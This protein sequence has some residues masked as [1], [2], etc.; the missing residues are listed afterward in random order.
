MEN[1]ANIA[2][3]LGDRFTTNVQSTFENMSPQ[4]WL[5]VVIVAGA[6]MLLRPYL[7]KLGG[8]VQ[9]D[10]HEKEAI[11]R[12]EQERLAQK[13]KISPNDLRGLMGKVEVPEDTDSEEE[14][15]EG[16][17][18]VGSGADWG[19]NARRRQRKMIKKLL[20]AE[21]KRLMETK[22][23]EEDKDIEEFLIKD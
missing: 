18:G 16:N 21:E 13:G 6:Y 20:E 4:K 1:L 8:K 3:T 14:E 7:I 17:S 22:E 11:E 23:M 2:S 15:E 5:R 9:M 10:T 12:E 19:K